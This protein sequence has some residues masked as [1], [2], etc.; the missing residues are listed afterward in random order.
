MRI[1]WAGLINQ[2]TTKMLGEDNKFNVVAGFIP[3]YEIASALACLATTDG[4]V[5]AST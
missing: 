5:I 4:V 3:A 1:N 2:A